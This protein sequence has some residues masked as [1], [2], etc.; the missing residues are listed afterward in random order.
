MLGYPYAFFAG[1]IFH[2]YFYAHSTGTTFIDCPR[3]ADF[4]I[5]P[6]AALAA[7]T[8]HQ[9]DIVFIT[10]PNNPTGDVTPLDTITR[11][12][13]AAPGIVIVDEAYAEFSDSLASM[14]F[15]L[16]GR[17][18]RGITSSE[19]IEALDLEV[20]ALIPHSKT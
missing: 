10:T 12:L 8:E 16:Q 5:D 6:Q 7:I 17:M 11:I 20:S 1:Y 3:G 18:R 19:E 13:D 15:L 4:C 2:C 9:P 14:W